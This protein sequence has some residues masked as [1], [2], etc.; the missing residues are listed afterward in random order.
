MIQY[1]HSNY[2]HQDEDVQELFDF[3]IE[4]WS[5]FNPEIEEYTLEHTALHQ[6]FV[7]LFETKV[8]KFLDQRGME[9]EHLYATLRQELEL[10]TTMSALALAQAKQSSSD[11]DHHEDMKE[12][13]S[14]PQSQVAQLL[15]IFHQVLDFTCWA[16][17]MKKAVSDQRRRNCDLD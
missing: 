10:D 7:R 2:D 1:F 15:R 5:K 8:E 9:Q 16:E 4:C 13:R 6:A 14:L 3:E 11:E 12:Y 17:D